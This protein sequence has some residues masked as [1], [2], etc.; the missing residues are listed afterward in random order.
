MSDDRS[1]NDRVPAKHLTVGKLLELIA[2]LD[3]SPDTKVYTEGCDCIGP[4]DGVRVDDQG[5]LIINR[6]DQL[7]E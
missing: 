4:S 5:E 1:M 7:D 2:E 6:N 3:L